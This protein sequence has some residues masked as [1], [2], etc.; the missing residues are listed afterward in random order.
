MRGGASASE[1]EAPGAR[2]SRGC[3]PRLSAKY[4]PVRITWLEPQPTSAERPPVFPNPFDDF[5]PHPLAQRCAEVLKASLCTGELAPGVSTAPLSRADGGKMFGV[6]AVEAGDGR[7]GFLRA[8][9][10]Q[11]FGAWDVPGYA[12]P[13]F[14]AATR[15]RIEPL[16]S[17][18]VNA[19]T[20]RV[21]AM[22]VDP[23]LLAAR[24]ALT[25]L[26]A[27]LENQR[28]ALKTRNTA[29]KAA[30]RALRATVQSPTELDALAQ[31]SRRDDWERRTF[32]QDARARLDD[33]RA[34]LAP[35]TR[36]LQA[37]ERLRRLV[38][39]HAMRDL[40]DTYTVTSFSGARRAL[41]DFFPEADP[42]S[43]AA[44]CAAPKLLEAARREGL[45]PLALAEFWWGAPPPGGGR[46]EGAWFPACKEKCGPVVPFQL[47]GLAVAP[48]RTHRPPDLAFLELEV[49]YE[50]D[51]V[52]AVNKPSG[53]LSVFAKD[54]RI[55]DSVLARVR[56]RF[57]D[58]LPVHRLDLDTSGVL[59][60]AKHL[61]A[62]RA[63]QAQFLARTVG[64]Q[65]EAIVEG[66][67]ADASGLISLP[68][69]VDLEHRPRQ[70]VDFEHGREARTRWRRR[71]VEQGR[72]HVTF[73]P[74]TGRTH[75]LRVH[76]AHPR[77][78]GA[79]IVG[80]RFYGHE[81]ERL[82]LHAHVLRVTHP[83]TGKPLELRAPVPFTLGREP[84]G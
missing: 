13:L 43:G 21:E 19:L 4:L 54:E 64:K 23:A 57:P 5:P 78:L 71:A 9:S 72:T 50:D 10:G 62:Y 81:A 47:E 83:R 58:A 69:R 66:A 7:V 56:L 68:L 39:I 49:L 35:L 37:L 16:H 48:R 15:A 33:A 2:G 25:T 14:D 75:Q 76:A 38:S 82:L 45:R 26:E 74:E 53:L 65:Y 44:D 3:E 79:P 18:T 12:L 61:D 73:F 55:T 51:D 59:L 17:Q 70:V 8:F 11:Y 42:P 77:G 28:E 1:S 63:V 20:A 41:R 80:D 40:W 67:L 27:A 46:V 6:L 52:L 30:R 24:E 31:Q 32:E 36:K 29:N 34:A 84:R 60:L 22:R